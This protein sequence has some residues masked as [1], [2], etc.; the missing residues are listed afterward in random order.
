MMDH[1]GHGGA[2]PVVLMI[3]LVAAGYLTLAAR[4]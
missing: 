4:R 1:G 2:A 3:A